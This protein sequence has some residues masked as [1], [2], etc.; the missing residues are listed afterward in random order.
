MVQWRKPNSCA[1]MNG[2]LTGYRYRVTDTKGRFEHQGSLT[3]CFLNITSLEPHT[4]YLM[5]IN[6]LNGYIHPFDSKH[7][8]VMTVWTRPLGKDKTWRKFTIN[9]EY[10]SN[11]FLISAP[12][13]PQDLRVYRSASDK[14]G[15][16]WKLP[17]GSANYPHGPLDSATITYMNDRGAR[18]SQR[19]R[20]VTPCL[21]FPNWLCH[22][23]E[24]LHQD[25]FYNITASSF[26]ISV[27][28]ETAHMLHPKQHVILQLLYNIAA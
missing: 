24:N 26:G 23:L 6:V 3:E 20:P 25:M 9:I 16:R 10:F 1:G 15:L 28:S 11:D 22:D 17:N 21:A 19:V 12:G 4:K 13:A 27:I 5:E 7:A 14:L 2:P 18:S 8:L